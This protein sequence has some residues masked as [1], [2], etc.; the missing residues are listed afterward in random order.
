MANRVGIFPKVDA[1]LCPELVVLVA[2]SSS[3]DARNEGGVEAIGL[4]MVVDRVIS[5][6]LP[7]K[8]EAESKNP[9]APERKEPVN[10]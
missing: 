10:P 3:D 1:T 5:A 4:H 2:S 8:K 7:T 6:G 9:P